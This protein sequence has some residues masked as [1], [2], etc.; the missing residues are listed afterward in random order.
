MAHVTDD[1][2][3]EST[4]TIGTT[5]FALAGALAGYRALGAVM[6]SPSDT[7]Y[8]AAWLVDASGNPTG[9]FE[10]GLG[11]YSAANT[12]TRTTV[13][14]SSNANAIVTFSA[15]TK[16]VA[17]TAV[18][19]RT[20]QLEPSLAAQFPIITSEPATPA[21]GF[22]AVYAKEIAGIG[23]IRYKNA[24]GLDHT[25]Q[26]QLA[27]N[28][29]ETCFG[30]IAAPTVIG[31]PTAAATV[32]NNAV[33][34]ALAAT[35]LA[36]QM[37]HTVM[38]TTA[39]AGGLGTHI[40]APL[41]FW[42]GNTAGAGGFTFTLRFSLLALQAGMRAFWGIQDSVTPLTNV[43]YTTATAPGKIGLAIIA[44]TGNWNLVHNITA[45]APTVIALGANFPV[46]ITDVLELNLSCAPNGSTIGYR[47]RNLST[48]NETSGA[49]STNIPA[50]T[51]FMC[52][53]G[54]I[55][56]NATAAIASMRF[57]KWTKEADN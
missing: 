38:S 17:I 5:A 20:L 55:T 9:E 29:F 41:R 31:G 22:V 36:T 51:T 54:A 50:A 27:V 16:Y 3:L 4:T 48:G 2:V 8:Y 47:V 30:G 52:P 14:R 46:N 24:Q 37:L 57:Y 39:T 35:N 25:I 26:K 49:L 45:S 6:T 21:A 43:D 15:G 12:L 19:A 11:T 18:A 32:T 23:V 13:M 7:C 44:N 56:N 1:R 28:G 34:A 42:R 40:S 53:S 33:S 10:E